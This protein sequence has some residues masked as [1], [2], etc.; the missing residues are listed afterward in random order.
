[1]KEE[2][3]RKSSLEHL[4][5]LEK[6]DSCVKVTTPKA[7]LVTVGI[8]V[9]MICAGIWSGMASL[10]SSIPAI[11]VVQEGVI[12]VFV[13]P[14]QAEK[15]KE[16]MTVEAKGKCIGEI[17]HVIRRPIRKENAGI[18]YLTE[19]FRDTKL[20]K[21]NVELLIENEAELPEGEE[22]SCQIVTR[23]TKIQKLITK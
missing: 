17:T 9:L 23:E 7:W 12:H 18:P 11:G 5:S 15:L 19:Y 4:T 13:S 10:K 20:G 1:M 2:L 21:W 22:I 3:F 8:L 6:L 14:E 16:G